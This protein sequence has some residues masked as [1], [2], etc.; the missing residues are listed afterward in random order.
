[1]FEETKVFEE[2]I[3]SYAGKRKITSIK[4]GELKNTVKNAHWLRAIGDL[5]RNRSEVIMSNN[6]L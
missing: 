6:V 3:R 2:K 1:M 5:S 4:T